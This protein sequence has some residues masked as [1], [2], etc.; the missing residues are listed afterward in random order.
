MAYLFLPFCPTPRGTTGKEG[1]SYLLGKHIML[2]HYLILC[3][4]EISIKPVPTKTITEA[5]VSKGDSKG[6]P[7]IARS[8]TEITNKVLNVISKPETRIKVTLM[9]AEFIFSIRYVP[10]HR[11]YSPPSYLYLSSLYYLYTEVASFL[12][13]ILLV[14]S[15]LPAPFSL[16]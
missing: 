9:K 15:L 7:H 16:D 8:K 6:K 3:S 1:L 4:N 14:S 12:C 5:S 13:H 11:S 10:R 2:V